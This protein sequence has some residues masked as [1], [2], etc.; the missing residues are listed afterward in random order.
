MVAAVRRIAKRSTE[1][2]MTLVEVLVGIAIG[3]IG[4]LIMFQTVSVWDARSRSST[5]S[6]DAQ[7]AGT[8]AMFALERDVRGAGLGFGTAAAVDMGC[9]VQATDTLAGRAFNF[10]LRPVDIIDGDAT[11]DPDQIRTAYG[12]SAFFVSTQMFTAS[13][14]T[15]KRTVRR[16]GFKRGDVVVVAGNDVGTPGSSA[17]QLIQITDDT[18]VDGFTIAHA[19]GNYTN[20]YTGGAKASQFNPV[21]GTGGVYVAGKMYN[22]GPRPRLMSWTV[23]RAA[24]TLS[25]ADFMQNDPS[26]AVAEG[27]V[28]MK[29]Q[30][31]IDTDG[32]GLI[33]DTAPNEWTKV[34]PANWTTVRAIRIAVLVRSRNFE[35][36]AASAADVAFLQAS[37]P[38]W[39][40]GA[41]AMHNVDGTADTNPIG[42]PN[43]WRYYRYRV[44]EKVIPLRNMVWGTSP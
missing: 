41:F 19:N 7:V 44:Y 13:T 8:L 20:F 38:T 5:S 31:G 10:P 40:G 28:D 6:S 4:V 1:R 2:G 35:K 23:D 18:N 17:C 3:M 36:P 43:N 26:T 33:T 29:A 34:A 12:N 15:T 16:G 25:Y 9:I 27:V 39:S 21:G 32:N 22:L 24:G 37:A 14:S 42:S 30:F 11:G